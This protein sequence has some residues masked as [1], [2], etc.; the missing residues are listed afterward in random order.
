MVT[1]NSKVYSI[2]SVSEAKKLHGQ[3]KVEYKNLP[4]QALAEVKEYDR[5]RKEKK[6]EKQTSG[7]VLI[8]N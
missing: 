5:G 2:S 6:K 1:Y 3:W 8:V 4:T 7:E